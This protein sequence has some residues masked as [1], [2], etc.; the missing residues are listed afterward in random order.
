MVAMLLLT[1]VC[2]ASIFS[3]WLT[4]DNNDPVLV[5]DE[6]SVNIW[7]RILLDPNVTGESI[8]NRGFSDMAFTVSTPGTVRLTEPDS[9]DGPIAAWGS[10]FNNWGTKISPTI[11]EHDADGDLDACEA[12]MG[13]TAGKKLAIGT[14]VPVLLDTEIWNMAKSGPAMLSVEV[15]Y[16]ARHWLPDGATRVYFSMVE[17]SGIVVT[18]YDVPEP[19]TISLLVIG[20]IVMFNKRKKQI[21]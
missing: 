3:C 12:A 10:A 11:Q 19:A 8:T 4:L 14:T 17:T 15:A 18:G 6:Y 16:G 13:D 7:A 1:T 5:G 9:A 21:I 2:N 20:T